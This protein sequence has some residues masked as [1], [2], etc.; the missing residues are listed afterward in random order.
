MSGTG[1][2]AIDILKICKFFFYLII[3]GIKSFMSALIVVMVFFVEVFFINKYV[4]SNLAAGIMPVVE[5]ARTNWVWIFW[6]VFA[7][8]LIINYRSINNKQVTDK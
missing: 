3:S 2:M 4:D 1:K 5:L 8:E 7:F 6:A